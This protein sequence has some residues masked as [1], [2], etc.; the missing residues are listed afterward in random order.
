MMTGRI[1]EG[2]AAGTALDWLRRFTRLGDLL[3]FGGDR[4]RL[5]RLTAIGRLGENK[6]L[7]RFRMAIAVTHVGI[8]QDV[9]LALAVDRACLN[10]CVLGLAPV[11]AGIHAQRAA[12]GTWHAAIERKSREPGI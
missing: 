3:H 7:R 1:L 8:L 4:R 2:R 11:S 10:Q 12:D 9:K 6:I 5:A